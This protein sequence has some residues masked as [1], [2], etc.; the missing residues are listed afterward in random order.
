MIWV[1]K[2]EKERKEEKK[3]TTKGCKRGRKRKTFGKGGEK[4]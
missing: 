4:K 3:K 2:V 1:R